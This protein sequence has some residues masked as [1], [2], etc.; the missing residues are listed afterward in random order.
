MRT[1]CL[2]ILKKQDKIK[3]S[4]FSF[5]K[6]VTILSAFFVC[7]HFITTTAAD[8]LSSGIVQQ[9]KT[10]N[11]NRMIFFAGR[12]QLN[13]KKN[14][15]TI[16]IRTLNEELFQ[17]LK[18]E[19]ESVI[20]ESTYVSKVSTFKDEGNTNAFVI[21][22][23]LKNSNVEM[24]SFYREREK[25][26]VLDMW[27]DGEETTLSKMKVSETSPLSNASVA[28]VEDSV[29]ITAAQTEK[30]I[31]TETALKKVKKA[32]VQSPATKD[33]KSAE[34]IVETKIN[35]DEILKSIVVDPN[36]KLQL[37][38]KDD[39][40]SKDEQKK[41]YR[42]FRYGATFFWDYEP[43]VPAMK[44]A[45]NLEAKTPE[46]FYPIINRK[47]EKNEREAHLQL[48][49]NLFRKKN[50]GL[51]NK[52]ISLFQEKYGEKAEWELLEYLKINALL[53][54]NIEKPNTEIFKNAIGRLNG[55]VE[56]SDNYELKKGIWKYLLTFYLQKQEFLKTL[57]ISKEFYAGTRSSFDFEE[58]PYPAEVMLYSL[59][60][61]GQVQQLS[62]LAQE[63][64]IRKVI[65]PATVLSYQSF[66][67]LKSGEVDGAIALYEKSRS[68]VI[69]ELPPAVLYNSAE[70]YFRKGD[71]LKAFSMYQRFV[72]EFPYELTAS[73]AQLRVAL[74]SDILERN[75]EETLALYKE[76]VDKAINS[77]ISYEAR[78]RYVAF[79]SVRKNNLDDRDREIRI[80]LEQDKT[81]TQALNK[82]LQRLLYQVRLRTLIVDGKFK[83]ALAYYSLIPTVGM[84]K[85]DARTFFADAAEI[86]YGL[87]EENYKKAEYTQVIKNWQTY[88]DVY[89]NKVASDPYLK[90][91]VGSAYVK[92]GLFNGFDGIY[93]QFKE[94]KDD[95]TR[96]FPLWVLRPRDISAEHLLAE[97]SIIKDLKL[98]NT[99]LALKEV[100]D[101]I[102]LTPE[103]KRLYAYRGQIKYLKKDH[104]GAISDIETYLSSQTEKTIY[105]PQEIAD[106]VRAYT[107][108][109]YETNDTA[110]Y[111]KVAQAILNDTNS[112][113]TKNAYMQSVLE[114]I[115][116]LAI[117]IQGAGGKD[118]IGS[119]IE[120]MVEEFKKNHPK[121]IYLGRI[122][123]LYGLQL[124]KQDRSKEGRDIFTSLVNDKNV[125]D[126]IKELAKSELSILNLKDK[127]L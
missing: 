92:L 81:T 75:F 52:S 49:I 120:K 41:A 60:R 63:K 72:K 69:G 97:L 121:S 24:F 124:V 59:A 53:R 57:Q 30:A 116:Y 125:S 93:K 28:Q 106:I 37:T 67:K 50:F 101:L 82:N 122:T 105:D 127:T 19:L 43:I 44:D 32:N 118:G 66:A 64:N 74:C 21:N 87:I 58:S 109:I 111:T 102:K 78:L 80:F 5:V 10:S 8:T 90:F 71:Y 48:T 85:V 98:R 38:A 115:A 17:S 22:F 88:K 76:A 55:I 2:S 56:R 65:A 35:Q 117:E 70:A 7:S 51:M 77:D 4:K 36:S 23:E 94:Q 40:I 103:N 27:L 91:L 123:Y 62:E 61:L 33:A 84:T 45:V 86:A 9:E 47:F 26:Y 126:Y 104:K 107:D 99:D 11:Y 20:A 39:E 15:A 25:K 12:D 1:G 119:N 114:R 46:S 100:E 73:N 113:G 83:E 68:G 108:S 96:K 95:P 31:Q 16:Q 13:F 79:R 34:K 54:E 14:G 89:V 29:K 6:K 3:N 18:S 112:L 42:D 110:K